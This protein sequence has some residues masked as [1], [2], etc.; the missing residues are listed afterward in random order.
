MVTEEVLA[1]G[2][3]TAAECAA[4]QTVEGTVPVL[5]AGGRTPQGRLRAPGLLAGVGAAG[6]SGVRWQGRN[7]R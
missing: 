4:H 7:E 5:Q 2:T 1:A 3:E 6:W